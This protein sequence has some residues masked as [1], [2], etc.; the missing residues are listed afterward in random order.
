[1]KEVF[2]NL[3]DFDGILAITTNGFVRDLGAF[4]SPLPVMGM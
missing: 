4:A 3:W 2:G 1:M